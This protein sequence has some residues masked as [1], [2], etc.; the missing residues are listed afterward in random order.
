MKRSD[1]TLPADS[2]GSI[3][4]GEEAA[5][6]LHGHNPFVEGAKAAG[7]RRNGQF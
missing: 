6:G 7:W 2:D 1:F 3:G 5:A 4:P